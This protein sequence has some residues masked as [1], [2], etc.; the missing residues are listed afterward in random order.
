MLP[1]AGGRIEAL[2]SGESE[3]G[4]AAAT[5]AA[6]KEDQRASLQS[7]VERA[8]DASSARPDLQEALTGRY[9]NLMTADPASTARAMKFFG[10]LF[11]Q[12]K[13]NPDRKTA[14]DLARRLILLAAAAEDLS[15]MEKYSAACAKLLES[16][17]GRCGRSRSLPGV[18]AGERCQVY[19]CQS[20]KL[21]RRSGKVRAHGD[22]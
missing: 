10:G 16:P 4:T 19:T 7:L 5:A 13:E 8:V 11:D 22:R 12:A 17:R 3:E 18:Q 6:L 15:A 2:L 21:A 9:L 14:I 20:G 1:R